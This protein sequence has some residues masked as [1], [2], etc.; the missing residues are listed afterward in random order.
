MWVQK[1]CKNFCILVVDELDI[2][3]VEII[4][5]VHSG[6]VSNFLFEII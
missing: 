3:L 6:I 2:V 5:F 4:L 1:L